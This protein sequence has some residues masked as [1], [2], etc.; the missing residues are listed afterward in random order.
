MRAAYT[1]IFGFFQ[2]FDVFA[3]GVVGTA[4]EAA[5]GAAVFVN[6][7]ATA[8]WAFAPIQLCLLGFGFGNAL[9][10]LGGGFVCIPGIV[11]IGITGTGDES[12]FF[13]K[14]DLQFVLS[15]F[16]AGFVQLFGGEFGTFDTGFFFN[17]FVEAFP[18]FVHH[19]YPLPLAA[20]D[21]VQLVFQLGGEIVIYVLLEVFG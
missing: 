10:G 19:G 16:G 18:E 21:V 20:G 2:R 4:D 6:Q 8:F 1:G 17:L 5:A 13:A 11:A 14:L 15:A 9:G 3:L 12:S 7:P